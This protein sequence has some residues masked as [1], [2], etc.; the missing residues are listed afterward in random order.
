MLDKR[1]P[2]LM[3]KVMHELYLNLKFFLQEREE[4]FLVSVQE[5]FGI[6]SRRRRSRHAKALSNEFDHA[7]MD[8]LTQELHETHEMAQTSMGEPHELLIPMLES[9]KLFKWRQLEQLAQ[10]YKAE[11]DELAAAAGEDAADVETM[12][13]GIIPQG[14]ELGLLHFMACLANKQAPRPSELLKALG[15]ARPDADYG[16]LMLAEHVPDAA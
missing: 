8:S 11:Y 1:I 16:K 13:T 6:E 4:F 2:M 9:A 10:E 3:V 14:E 15:V 7:A 5:M 12:D